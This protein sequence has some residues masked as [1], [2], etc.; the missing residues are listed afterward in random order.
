MDIVDVRD[1]LPLAEPE[2]RIGYYGPKTSVTVHW[3]GP[4][5][6]RDVD[7]LDVILGDAHYHISKDWSPEPGVQGGDGIMYHFLVAPDGRVFKTRDDDAVLYHCGSAI[8][9]ERS[10][11][12]QV[13]VGGDESGAT[14]PSTPITAEQ[15]SALSQLIAF[16]GLDQVKPHRAWSS[17]TCPGN[18]LADWVLRHAWEEVLDMD[19]ATLRKIIREE[20]HR[21][22]WGSGDDPSTPQL[23][24]TGLGLTFARVSRRIIRT[25]QGAPRD[26]GK[27]YP[28]DDLPIA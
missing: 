26:P 14:D 20:T 16:L 17:T 13:M 4:P 27:E 6:P 1:E 9:N 24:V 2:D 12:V 11:A 7:P 21:A 19:E 18:E 3:N 5:V 15:L 28:D 23:E 25:L 22:I 10:Y 8:G